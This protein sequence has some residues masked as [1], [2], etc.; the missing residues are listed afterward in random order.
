MVN[1]RGW[2][3][4]VEASI[5][6]LIILGVLISVNSGNNNT[7]SEDLSE[8][9]TPLLEEIASNYTLRE[10]VVQNSANE[11][12]KQILEFLKTKITN[13]SVDY[14]VRV[15]LIEDST[16]AL[17]TYPSQEVFV[18]ERVISSVLGNISP[19]RV[20]IFMWKI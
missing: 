13:P 2:L 16:C 5:A 17:E 19:K 7:S 12:E 1:K 18:Q 9:I 20:K 8:K 6:I 10:S 15:C 4:I 14:T 3:R 11:S